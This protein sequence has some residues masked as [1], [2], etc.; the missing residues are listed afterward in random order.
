MRVGEEKRVCKRQWTEAGEAVTS[1]LRGKGD[2]VVTQMY[3]VD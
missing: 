1:R 2:G 3:T